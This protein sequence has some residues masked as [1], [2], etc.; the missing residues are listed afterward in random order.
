MKNLNLTAFVPIMEV[1]LSFGDDDIDVIITDLNM[2]GIT[3]T[4]T[5]CVGGD[6]GFPE[7]MRTPVD[8]DTKKEY[9]DFVINKIKNGE[10]KIPWSIELNTSTGEV[11][12]DE[13][14]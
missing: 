12:I 11:R 9:T 13:C 8:D 10:L 7:E 3:P 1:V 2:D 5:V 14:I 4:I 6:A